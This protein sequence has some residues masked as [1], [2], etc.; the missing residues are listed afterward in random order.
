MREVVPDGTGFGNIV[1]VD[2]L[3]RNGPGVTVIVA[4]LFVIGNPSIVALICR[5]VPAV[6]PVNVAVYVPSWLSVMVL[7]VPALVPLP[8]SRN[9]TACPPAMSGEPKT[10][11]VKSVIVT[12]DP[13][14]IVDAETVM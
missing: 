4:G 3:R 13:D 7:I 11:S 8:S 1:R 6:V 10:F 14:W 12:V 9:V 2:P 5:A